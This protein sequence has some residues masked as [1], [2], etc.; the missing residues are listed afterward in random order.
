MVNN[1][2]IN[3]DKLTPPCT[4]QGGKQRIASNIIDIILNTCNINEETKFI[5]LCCG[6]GSLSLELI[7]R[8]FNPYNIIMVDAGCMGMFWEAVAINEFNL[9]L[10][11]DK[12]NDIPSIEYIQS[13]LKKISKQSPNNE[14]VYDYLILQAGAFGSKQIWIENNQWKNCSFRNYWKP[15]STSNRKSPVNPMM[16]MPNTLFERVERIVNKI[17]G[18]INGY[19][20]KSEDYIKWYFNNYDNNNVIIYI[21][22]P[23]INTTKYGFEINLIE[24]INHI[25]KSIPIFISEGYIME[26]ANQNWI[27]DINKNKGNISGKGNKHYNKEYLNLYLNN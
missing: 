1:M 11:K 27:I 16:P 19:Y 3:K 20:G 2:N 21:D 22:P 10:F 24:T 15:N 12:I 5:D 4:Y 13:Y 18:K 7:N 8:G 25:P 14:I 17:G 9:K 26:Y 23:Y 6:S